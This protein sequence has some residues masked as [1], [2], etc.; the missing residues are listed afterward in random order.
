MLCINQQEKHLTQTNTRPF[1]KH[2]PTKNIFEKETENKKERELKTL[3]LRLFM[4]H[5][6]VQM[7]L[8]ARPWA[9]SSGWPRITL[10]LSS[11]CAPMPE[12]AI[13]SES[14]SPLQMHR[15]LM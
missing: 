10:E 4:Q 12:R 13:R 11:R 2:R 14:A 7:Q 6:E 15:G 1:N 8:H 3:D 5:L 9:V